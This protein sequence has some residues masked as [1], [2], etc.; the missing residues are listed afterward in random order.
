MSTHD[1]ATVKA[2][3]LSPS[4]AE[5]LT[6]HVNGTREIRHTMT[7]DRTR[8]PLIAKGLVYFVMPPEI[9]GRPKETRLT[10]EGR[11]V[12]CALLAFYAERLTRFGFAFDTPA[13]SE[14]ALRQRLAL[15][16]RRGYGPIHPQENEHD[17]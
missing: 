5:F 1:T 11:D 8:N 17:D 3:R 9:V 16:K 4:Q 2:L 13:L 14:A 6:D 15:T 7:D 10:E 12:L